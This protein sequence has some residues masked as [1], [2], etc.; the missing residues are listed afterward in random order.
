MGRLSGWVTANK[1]SLSTLFG[2]AGD[3]LAAFG[4]ITKGVLGAFVGSVSDGRHSFADFAKFLSTHQADIIKGFITGARV[5]L[6]FADSQVT[7]ASLGLRAFAF[8]VDGQR[9][10]AEL[11]L[12]QFAMIT[13]GAALAFGWIPGVGENFRRA[14]AKFRTFASSAISGLRVT[15]GSARGMADVM[16]RRLR[17]AIDSARGRLGELERSEVSTARARDRAA[18]AAIG[19]AGDIRRAYGRIPKAVLT[20]VNWDTRVDGLNTK[21]VATYGKGARLISVASGGVLPGFTPGKD[22]HQFYSPTG[23]RLELSGGEAIMRPEWTRAVG[24]PKAVAK[25]NAAA[26]AGRAFAAGGVFAAVNME[27]QR[28]IR[29]AGTDFLARELRRLAAGGLLPI[30]AVSRPRALTSYHGGTFTRQFA[31]ALQMAERSAGKPFLIMQGG[32][33]PTTSYS[34]STHN[35]DAVDA[36]VDYVLLR[37]FRRYVGAMGDRT[38]LGNWASHMHGVPAPGHGYGSPSARA[39]YQDYLRR[40]GAR[41]SPRSPWGLVDGGVATEPGLYALAEKGPERALSARETRSFDNL[42]RVVSRTGGAVVH[43]HY[44]FD[45]YIGSRDEIRQFLVEASRRGKTS[46]F[47]R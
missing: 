7:M 25:M 10:A 19:N 11:M 20:V 8:L 38:G 3:T 21:F 26:K 32:F 41:Q 45:R 14:D 43:N 28:Y 18:R 35:M 27:G 12:G 5:V 31:A 23:G 39:Q 2:A 30:D 24:G 29:E 4:R 33:R 46:V 17:P 22:V 34:G 47:L 44:H 42:V 9:R 6:E 36:R 13:R 37:A 15:A 40:G 1:T 16:D